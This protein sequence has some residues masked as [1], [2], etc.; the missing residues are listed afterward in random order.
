[1]LGCHARLATTQFRL[2]AA[3]AKQVQLLAHGHG[4]ER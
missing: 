4:G 1:M 3:T 2:G